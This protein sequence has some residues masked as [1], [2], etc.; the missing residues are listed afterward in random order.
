LSDELVFEV[1]AKVVYQ[2]VD[3]RKAVI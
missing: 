2:I 1:G 3:L